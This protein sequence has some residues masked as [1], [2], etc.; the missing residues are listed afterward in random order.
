MEVFIAKVCSYKT[1]EPF[2]K[3]I[4]SRDLLAENAVSRE[5]LSSY[6]LGEVAALE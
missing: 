5:V 4:Q 6:F 2:K 3:E 1:F